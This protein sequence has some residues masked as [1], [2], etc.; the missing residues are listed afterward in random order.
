MHFSATLALFIVLA[1]FLVDVAD[2][3]PLPKK[4]SDNLTAALTT[5]S[6]GETTLQA[7]T[8]DRATLPTPEDLA[9]MGL[10]PEQVE[11]LIQM[12]EFVGAFDELTEEEMAAWEDYMDP[13]DFDAHMQ[14]FED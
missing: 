5:A 1:C 2:A 7:S 3:I 11:Q 10:T 4:G 9:Y 12:Y 13:E 14:K 6:A 8:Y